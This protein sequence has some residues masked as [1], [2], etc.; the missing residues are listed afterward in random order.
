MPLFFFNKR[1]ILLKDGL[2]FCSSLVEKGLINYEALSALACIVMLMLASLASLRTK[3]NAY[4]STIS[5]S[6]TFSITA[7]SCLYTG[8]NLVIAN[9]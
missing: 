4:M 7:C 8:R 5:H 6:Y 9:E 3:L 2:M 1:I